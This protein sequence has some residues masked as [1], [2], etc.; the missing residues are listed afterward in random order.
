MYH[1]QCQEPNFTPVQNHTQNCNFVYS[2]FYV[3]RQQTRRQNTFLIYLTSINLRTFSNWEQF[4]HLFKML[5]ES[6]SIS[7]FSTFTKVVPGWQ[8]LLNLFIPL[9]ISWFLLCCK[10]INFAFQIP[11]LFYSW[12][13][14]CIPVPYFSDYTPF[15]W[16]GNQ[17][18]SQSQS[19]FTTS[20]LP[21]ISSFWRQT[22]WD[23][24]P[25]LYFFFYFKWTLMV[26]ILIYHPLWRGDGLS[27]SIGLGFV[28]FTYRIYSI[29]LKIFV[30]S[31]YIQVLRQSRLCTSDNAYL[32]YRPC[33]FCS[34]REY[35]VPH[36]MEAQVEHALPQFWV[37]LIG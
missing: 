7:S 9:Y 13:V 22:S 30:F 34:G 1:P 17:S 31:I 23:S 16:L 10:H 26:A 32:T 14:C 6:T 27:L 28:K 29:I 24:W 20:G 11:P 4:F 36:D 21:S 19:Y 5:W 25:E 18:Q 37:V 15:I 3:F 12:N 35:K 33:S 8:L 2:N